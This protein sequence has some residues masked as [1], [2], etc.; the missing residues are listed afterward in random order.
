MYITH[1]NTLILFAF[2]QYIT[3]D[4]ALIV[5]A[6]SHYITDDNALILI[7]FSL[8]ISQMKIP[9]FFF[10]IPTSTPQRVTKAVVCAILSVGCCI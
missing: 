2:I 5:I 4:N 10:L 3:D 6:F 1:D 8:C 7:A 9:S